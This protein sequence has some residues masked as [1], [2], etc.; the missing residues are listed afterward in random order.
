MSAHLLRGVWQLER[1]GS[2]GFEEEGRKGLARHLVFLSKECRVGVVE[3]CGFL[4]A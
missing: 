3:G 2:V 4:S 1:F